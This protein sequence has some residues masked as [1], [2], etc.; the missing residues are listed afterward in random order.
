VTKFRAAGWGDSPQTTPK[1]GTARNPKIA[2]FSWLQGA[3]YISRVNC[4]KITGET[5]TTCA[6]NFQHKTEILTVFS[7]DPRSSKSPPY[8]G[9]KF[10][11]PL[12][13]ARFL[14]LL[15][16][17]VSWALAQISCFYS[18]KIPDQTLVR[19]T[20]ADQCKRQHNE[21][22]GYWELFQQ[23]LEST[24]WQCVMTNNAIWEDDQRLLATVS[25]QEPELSK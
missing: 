3:A 14:L 2:G 17:R 22:N 5:K 15:L 10:E 12:Q 1:K 16:L 11:Y 23:G 25:S 20:D 7:F 8:G 18:D 13:N 4:T 21:T 24:D 19:R 9:A 6:L